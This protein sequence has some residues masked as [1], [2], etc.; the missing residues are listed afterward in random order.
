MTMRILLGVHQFFP[1]RYTGTETY[2]LALARELRRRGHTVTVATHRLGMPDGDRPDSSRVSYEYAGFPVDAIVAPMPDH[3]ETVQSSYDAARSG[4]AFAAII[5]EQRPDLVH[6]T[7]LMRFGRGAFRA[8]QQA[9]IPYVVTLTDFFALCPRIILMDRDGSHCAG[10]L[11]ND[12]LWCMT[13]ETKAT[14]H[15]RLHPTE[16]YRDYLAH[17]TTDDL[18]AANERR[19]IGQRYRLLRHALH[20]AEALLAP[21]RFLRETF[22]RNGYAPD[23][24]AHS[25][26]GIEQE[27]LRHY[28]HVP[29]GEPLRVGFLGSMTGHK[30][31][32][33][34]VAAVRGLP[35]A[36]I[37]LAL[38]GEL[39]DPVFAASLRRQI[40]DDAR[41]TLHGTFAPE[42]QP[43]ILSR[44]DVVVVPS[45]WY[46]NSPLVLCAAVLAGIP[47]V[48]SDVGGITELV[49]HGENGLTFPPG[50]V[51]ALRAVLA[52]LV[53][54][55]DLVARLTGR[56]RPLRTVSDEVDALT[57][58]YTRI[59]DERARIRTSAHAPDDAASPTRR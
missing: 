25:P 33:I 30:G 23:L 35:D 57:T 9:H 21:T 4:A 37:Q 38:H 3:G 7:H 14:P 56:P 8:L 24:V 53:G 10:P 59:A 31:P 6:F 22:L 51:E 26:F 42:D 29:G 19:L 47:V 16:A 36:N 13:G 34:L 39:P 48:G 46:E 58:F 49:A 41:I 50:E 1:E 2:T 15:A 32:Q 45:L 17:L 5:A 11:F 44:L 43:G 27:W 55:R 52:R 28:R 54:D 18:A 20:G 12:C 40:G